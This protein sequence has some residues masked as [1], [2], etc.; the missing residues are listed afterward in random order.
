MQSYTED[1]SAWYARRIGRTIDQ[2]ARRID[3]RSAHGRL[4]TLVLQALELH[5]RLHLARLA[6]E[7]KHA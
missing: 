2:S 1:E 4:D 7:G 3:R 6:A 5:R